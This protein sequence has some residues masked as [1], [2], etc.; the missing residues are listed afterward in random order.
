MTIMG[1]QEIG[2][3]FLYE[4]HGFEVRDRVEL[5]VSRGVVDIYV[6][7]AKIQKWDENGGVE[8]MQRIG[9]LCRRGN[10]ERLVAAIVLMDI[11]FDYT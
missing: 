9:L 2:T 8:S 7:G 3:R 4:M 5:C 10:G 11:G 1:I 6:S